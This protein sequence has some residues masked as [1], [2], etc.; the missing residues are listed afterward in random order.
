MHGP[1]EHQV[2]QKLD[3]QLSRQQH[4]NSRNHRRHR[5]FTVVSPRKDLGCFLEVHSQGDED[6]AQYECKDLR[7]DTELFII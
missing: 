5:S 6:N 4:H 1:N 3:K 2:E 7:I